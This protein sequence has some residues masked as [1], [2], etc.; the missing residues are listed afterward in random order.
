MDKLWL[1]NEGLLRGQAGAPSDGAQLNGGHGAADVQIIPRGACGLHQLTSRTTLAG[2]VASH[3]ADFPR[4]SI[5]LMAAGFLSVQK[6]PLTARM[7][8]PANTT[9]SF[10]NRANLLVWS[11]ASLMHSK[12]SVLSSQ[13]LTSAAWHAEGS[14][15][16]GP[17][18]IPSARIRLLAP[19]LS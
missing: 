9:I 8:R 5:Q 11:K 2:M 12:P 6:L 10:S 4:P 19:P 1:A 17:R 18:V 13:A 14:C 3:T 15:T 7:L 16:T